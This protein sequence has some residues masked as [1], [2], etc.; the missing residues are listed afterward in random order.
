MTHLRRENVFKRSGLAALSDLESPEHRE[1]WAILE[2]DQNAF[3]ERRSEFLS[4]DY[5]WPRDPLHTWSRVWEYPYVYHHLKEQAEAIGRHGDC[6]VVD[7]GSAVTFFPFSVAKLGYHVHCLDIDATCGPDIDR[8]AA[9][10]PHAPGKVDFSLISNA[11]FPLE[12]EEVVTVYCVSVLEHIPDFENTLDEIFRILKPNG[13]LILTIDLDRC[14]HMPIDAPG[15]YRLRRALADRFDLM[16]PEFTVHPMDVL[17]YSTSPYSCVTYTV[18][19][20]AMFYLRQHA[21]KLLGTKPLP[22]LLDLACWGA[23]MKK[24]GSVGR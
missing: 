10:I 24:R 6:G 13:L 14:G 3:A 11:R 21:K 16:E 17:L 7:L 8:A 20:K 15:Y 22:A 12:D 4:E 5:R 18:W 23:V 1:L 9:A 19:K 2:R